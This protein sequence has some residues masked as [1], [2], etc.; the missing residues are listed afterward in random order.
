MI[1]EDFTNLER[2]TDVKVK[3]AP[4]TIKIIE[5]KRSSLMYIIVK[6]SKV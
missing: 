6:L 2:D 5:H 3:E 4:K 1:A